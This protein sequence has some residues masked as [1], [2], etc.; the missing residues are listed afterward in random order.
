MKEKETIIETEDECKKKYPT[1]NEKESLFSIYILNAL[2]QYSSAV[3]PITTGKIVEYLEKDYEFWKNSEYYYKTDRETF[4]ESQKKKVRRY[5]NTLKDCY[6][7]CVKKVKGKSRGAGD[8]W[9]YDILSDNQAEGIT[10]EETLSEGEIEFLVD[11]I[12]EAKILN[13]E[14]T[15]AMVDKLLRKT[16]LSASKREQRIKEIRN[17]AWEKNPNNELVWKKEDIQPYIPNRRVTFEYEGKSITA[18]TIGWHYESNKCFLSAQVGDK[19][20]RFSLEKIQEFEPI[21]DKVFDHEEDGEQ[22]V[23]NNTALDYLFVNI[24]ILKSAARERRGIKFNYLSYVVKNNRV[25]CEQEAKQVLPHSLVFNDGKYYLM[26]IDENATDMDKIAYFRVDLIV[27]LEC[28]EKPIKLSEWNKQVYDRIDKARLVEKHP[29]MQVGRVSKVVFLVLESELDRVRDAFG[30]NAKVNMT[31]KTRAVY[32]EPSARADQEPVEKKLVE[33]TVQT[34]TEEAY[35]WALANA[36]A[37]ELVSPQSIRDRIARISDPIYQLYTQSITDKV[38]ENYD[39]VINTGTFKISYK[40]DES[41]AAET[42]KELAKRG[43]LGVVDNVG[44][45]GD[46]IYELGDYFGDFI[47]AKRLCLRTHQLENIS[48]A[49]RLVN[50]EKID[51]TEIHIDDT[52]W[53]K[54]LKKL[55]QVVFIESTIS[56]LSV[57]SDHEDIYYLDISGTDVRDISFIEKYHKLDYLNIVACPIEDYSPL[58]TMQS[59]LRCLEIDERALEKIGEDRIRKRHIGISIIPRK[60]SPLWRVLI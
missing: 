50:L 24:P 14:S 36:D 22:A 12:S 1:V 37:V 16:P 15:L 10:T 29:L 8:K 42:Y 40:V 11:L 7:S 43:K 60:N 53:M 28:L 57:L 56:D 34:T 21:D 47:N 23:T 13:S 20:H 30:K 49:S 48:W 59:R 46:D 38:R 45:A 18:V 3:N 44:A 41:T 2:K 39:Y 32:A 51:F 17:E 6:G 31:D 54:N 9:Y 5:L 25:V 58:L 35:R 55:K 26:G 19:Y 4:L 52:S 33:V 27:D